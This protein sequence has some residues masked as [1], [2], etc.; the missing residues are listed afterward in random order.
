MRLVAL[1]QS[2]YSPRTACIAANDSSREAD[3]E[4]IKMELEAILIN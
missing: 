3:Q 1:S 2:V 4:V